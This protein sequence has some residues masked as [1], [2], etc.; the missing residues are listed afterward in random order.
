VLIRAPGQTPEPTRK[1]EN[2]WTAG[3][4]SRAAKGRIANPE[5]GLC[6][7]LL[8]TLKERSNNGGQP[9]LRG[10]FE[11]QRR[12]SLNLKVR[13]HPLVDQP[14]PKESP[15]ALN[16]RPEL[17][18][19]VLIPPRGEITSGRDLACPPGHRGR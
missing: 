16:R 4:L 13:L 6:A 10:Q 19:D 7:M 11:Q 3:A 9:S 1:R 2:L 17:V 12:K 5:Y 15:A 8:G 18:D 14:K